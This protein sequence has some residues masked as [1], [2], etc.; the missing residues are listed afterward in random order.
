MV[1]TSSPPAVHSTAST[2]VEPARYGVRIL[3]SAEE[4]EEVRSCWERWQ[5]HPNVDLDHFLLVCRAHENVRSPY[6]MVVSRENRPVALLAGRLE[7]ALIEPGIGYFKPFR[8]SVVKLAVVYQG[9]LGQIDLEVCAALLAA[10]RQI[11]KEGGAD[12]VDLYH[13]PEDSPLLRI[14]VKNVGFLWRDGKPSW[15]THWELSLPDRPDGLVQKM[16]SKHRQWIRRKARELD[17]AYPGQVEYRAFPAHGELAAVCSELE[18]VAQKTYQ[19]GLRSGFVNDTGHRERFA[20]FERRGALRV[21]LLYCDN[22]PKAFCLGFVYKNGFYFSETGYDP[23]LGKYEI[24]T[25]LF[26]H[27]VS[28]LVKEGVSTLNFGFGDAYYKKRFGDR[29]WREGTV[30]LYSRSARGLMIRT[31]AG[32]VGTLT[33]AGRAFARR[34]G[35]FDKVKTAWR[36]RLAKGAKARSEAAP[37]RSGP[38]GTGS[39]ES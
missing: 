10:L 21:W 14:A 27:M 5:T 25:L 9:L 23:D 33:A 12:V 19:R 6:V 31:C 3:R 30:R 16:K 2:L 32:S 4:I 38:N 20:L 18:R 39:G 1:D 11:L 26:L 36:Q 34:L 7:D 22:Q 37:D 15:S 29:S 13:L 35:V 17:E 24:G 28:E 8:F